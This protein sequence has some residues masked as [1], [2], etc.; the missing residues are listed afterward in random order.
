MSRRLGLVVLVLVAVLVGVDFG[1]RVV[2]QGELA[3]RA[4][5]AAGARSA[6]AGIGGFPFLG[7]LLLQG[8][9]PHLDVRLTDVPVGTL[10]LQ[11]VDVVLTGT[12][13]DRGALF[14]ARQVR[15][16]RITSGTATVTVTAGELSSAVGRTVLLPGGGQVV[17]EEAGRS[18][19]ATVR[20][21]GGR[22]LEV[23]VAGVPVLSSDLASS[24]LVP[25]CGLVLSVGLGEL[26]V[27]CH[28]S[29][30][31]ARVVQAL[32]GT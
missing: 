12:V 4:Q 8:S 25:A 30:V 27:S 14:S 24:P 6:S 7:H 18:L 28:V 32:A 31:P 9:V 11:S 20:V 19:P 29:P 17:V 2:A 26:T 10:E 13:V 16:D 21:L 15:V 22:V 23:L 5:K 1:A 3:S